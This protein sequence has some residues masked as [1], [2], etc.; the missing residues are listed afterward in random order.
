MGS[1]ERDDRM[2]LVAKTGLPE[3]PRDELLA[4]GIWGQCICVDRAKEIV[5]AKTGADDGFGTGD[6]GTVALFRAMA[7]HHDAEP[8]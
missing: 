6:H 7:S 5:I 4:I 3:D 2:R 1:T 8:S